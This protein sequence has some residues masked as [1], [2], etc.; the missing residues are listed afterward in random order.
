MNFLK[1]I[2][3][4]SVYFGIVSEFFPSPLHLIQVACAYHHF[5]RITSHSQFLY[6]LF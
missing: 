5:F 1:V 6:F 3:Q 4:L 2:L